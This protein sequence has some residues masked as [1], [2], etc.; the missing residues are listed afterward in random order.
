MIVTDHGELCNCT[1]VKKKII[2]QGVGTFLTMVMNK[3]LSYRPLFRDFQ[4]KVDKFCLMLVF[5]FTYLE[6]NKTFMHY[7]K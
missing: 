2:S 4:S 6:K 3:L 7:L 5:S 1:A